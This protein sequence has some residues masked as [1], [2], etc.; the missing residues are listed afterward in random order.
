[1]AM[2]DRKKAGAVEMGV[3]GLPPARE[4]AGETSFPFRMTL[5]FDDFRRGD[6]LGGNNGIPFTSI[7]DVFQKY[8]MR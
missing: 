6:F 8:E 5:P 7:A 3:V 2:L 1:M 4:T